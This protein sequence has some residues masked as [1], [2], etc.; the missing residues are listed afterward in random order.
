M[1]LS[2]QDANLYFK[3]MWSLQNYVNL[4]LEILPEVVTVDEYE[5]LPSSKKLGIRNA[6]YEHIELIDP[7]LK[8]NPQKLSGAELEIIRSW[9]KFQRGDFFIER[10]LKKYAVFIGGD[11][12]YAVLALFDPFD[13]VL[14]YVSLPYYTKAVLLP[15]KGKII[16]DG[17]LQ[18]YAASFGG[19]V[20]DNLK[21]TYL[22]A[23]Q[24]GRIIESFD[25]QKQTAKNAVS[26]QTIKDLGPIIEEIS[27]QA[28]KLRSS[29]GA[30]TI[31][32]PAFSLVKAS[33][34]LAKL[35]I[36][37]PND[38]D[39]LWKALKKIENAARKAETVLYRSE[40]Y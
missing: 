12:V 9:K 34:K 36:E 4:K 20:K 24:N 1:K 16:Y 17:L 35:A 29:S 22:A 40:Y 28:R 2:N 8:E 5:E 19:G 30:P 11:Q 10:L 32:S 23:K 15:F 14:P 31:H 6:L 39:E 13:E 21:E 3:L 33:I 37:N 26:K 27:Q 38:A 18:G 7:Y 25:P